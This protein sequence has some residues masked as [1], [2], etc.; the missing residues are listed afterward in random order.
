MTM[1]DHGLLYLFLGFLALCALAT[2]LLLAL[3]ASSFRRLT[4]DL[5]H[6]L[7]RL[8]QL[9]PHCDRFVTDAQRGVEETRALTARVRRIVQGVE[10]VVE[11][12]RAAATTARTQWVRAMRPLVSVVEALRGN[13]KVRRHHRR[14]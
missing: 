11:Q 4:V 13:G 9:L 5:Q 8:N 10:A 12:A 6:T 2:T 14:S 1:H 7:H 3:T